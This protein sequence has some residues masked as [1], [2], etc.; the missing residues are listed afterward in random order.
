MP[1]FPADGRPEDELQSVIESGDV[2]RLRTILSASPALTRVRFK[3]G[4]TPLHMAAGENRPE[5]VETL[6]VHGAELTS[7]AWHGHSPLSWALTCWAY[8]AADKLVDL[9]ATP[10][11]FCASGLGRLDLVQTFWRADLLVANA[12]RTGSS[13]YTA[14]GE[15]LPAPPPDPADQVSDALYLACRTGRVP[16]SEWLLNHGADPN[17]RGY[18]GATC[19][20]W[21][22]F[23]GT[24]ELGDL[25]R[26]HGG[27]D[28]ARDTQF[29]ST[30]KAFAMMV[31][32][33]WGFG[34]KLA[35]RLAADPSLVSVG[36][37][38]TPLHAAA[39]GGR[40]GRPRSCST[41]G[42]TGVPAIIV[43]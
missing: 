24:S 6:V 8:D 9:G 36:D 41:L 43:G 28:E 20:A 10:D 33:G 17:W 42:P 12:S 1:E 29:D 39:R 18:A 3:D 30:P 5:L 13:R 31:L 27:S 11:L 4:S 32:A 14:D 40:W 15:P 38:G 25:L 37:R 23:S 21:A 7:S 22:E 2:A 35:E 34:R 16:V 26:R 19:L